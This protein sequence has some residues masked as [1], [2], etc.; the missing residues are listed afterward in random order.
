MIN[1]MQLA[2][3]NTPEEVARYF[4]VGKSTIMDA[5]SQNRLKAIKLTDRTYRIKRD[6]VEQYERDMECRKSTKDSKQNSEK[7]AERGKSGIM[8]P[9]SGNDSLAALRA[10]ERLKMKKNGSTGSSAAATLMN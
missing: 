9:E 10:I 5:I 2:E 1:E 3:I 7:I 4:R 8:Q 6:S